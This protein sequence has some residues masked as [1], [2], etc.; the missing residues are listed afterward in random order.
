MNTNP[1][2]M[3]D[4]KVRG[5]VLA[6]LGLLMILILF[7]LAQEVNRPRPAKATGAPQMEVYTPDPIQQPIWQVEAQATPTYAPTPEPT[8]S[9]EPTPRPSP[10]PRPTEIK[11]LRRG[12]KSEEVRAM[13][14]RLIE[15]NY[16]KQGAADG[17]YGKGTMAAVQEF[18]KNNGLAPDGVAGRE[19]I[20]RI[21]SQEA[22]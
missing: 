17:S 6:V 9:P 11:A 18:Q 3:N 7:L 16:L 10:T 4:V 12:D 20:T 22:R 21:F 14:Q 2:H 8:P 5:T 1:E 13:Q 19:T 15:L